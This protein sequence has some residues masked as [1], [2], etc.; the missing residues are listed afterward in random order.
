MS[1]FYHIVNVPHVLCL[2]DKLKLLQPLQHVWTVNV[3][4]IQPQY[5]VIPNIGIRIIWLKQGKFANS[6]RDGEWQKNKNKIKGN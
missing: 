1:C 4:D 2:N 3:E 5:K 6:V